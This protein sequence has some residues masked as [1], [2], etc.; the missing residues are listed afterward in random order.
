MAAWSRI[1]KACVAGL[2]GGGT[3][4]NLSLPSS[5]PNIP[6]GY[7]LENLDT[8]KC[9]ITV[10]NMQYARVCPTEGGLLLPSA[11]YHVMLG[12]NGEEVVQYLQ[13]MSEKQCGEEGFEL[14][15]EQSSLC[16]EAVTN[17][18]SLANGLCLGLQQFIAEK[19]AF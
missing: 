17:G 11:N 2:I 6:V 8:Q 3:M 13:R 4:L 14:Q 9:M 1:E 19:Y 18:R 10:V 12:H 5:V 7:F 16:H 15:F